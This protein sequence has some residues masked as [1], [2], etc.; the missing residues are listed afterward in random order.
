MPCIAMPTRDEV[1]LLRSGFASP[2]CGFLR[3]VKKAT[4]ASQQRTTK[5]KTAVGRGCSTSLMFSRSGRR[6]LRR[7]GRRALRQTLA[8]HPRSLRFRRVAGILGVSPPRAGLRARRRALFLF[9][10]LI[11]RPMAT[12]STETQAARAGRASG[13]FRALS[14]PNFRRFLT[15]SLL[16]NA[17]TWMQGV[18][19]SWLVLPLTNSRTLLGVG[20]F[21]STAPGLAL[22]L[23][24]GV[25]AAPPDPQR[26]PLH[27]HARPRPSPPAPPP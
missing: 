26:L 3:K 9:P 24:G 1:S 6:V 13:M 19:Q 7:P 10:A 25:I 17:G 4:K 2:P 14:H 12:A 15:G 16:S 20:D 21:M 22:T 23:V 8:D 18:A 27:P 5:T 11:A